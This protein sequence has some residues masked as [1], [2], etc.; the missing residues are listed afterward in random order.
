MVVN[1]SAAAATKTGRESRRR[2]RPPRIDRD[3]IVATAVELGLDSFSMEGVATRLGVTPPA[4][5]SHVSGRDEILRLA[6]S[7]VMGSLAPGLDLLSSWRDWLTG[8]AVMLRARLGAV[9][10]ELLDAI[11]DGLDP[12]A[13]RV[14]ERGVG[15]LVEAGLDPV[16]SGHALW[17]VARTAFTAGSPG[18]RPATASVETARAVIGADAGPTMAEAMDAVIAA[19]ADDSFRFDLDVL[20]AGIAARIESHA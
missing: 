12:E 4:L 7:E 11:G 19:G 14:A 15:L 18:E 10:E 8:W 17:L 3:R 2:G 9:G 5:Y 6:A 1:V 13:L 20:V 16:E